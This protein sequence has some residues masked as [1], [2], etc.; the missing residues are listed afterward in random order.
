MYM[1]K[2]LKSYVKFSLNTLSIQPL[3][4]TAFT[5]NMTVNITYYLEGVN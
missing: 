1:N 2:E 4:L 5:A 3:S